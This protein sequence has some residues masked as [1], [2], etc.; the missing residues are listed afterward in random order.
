MR[1]PNASLAPT[2]LAAAMLMAGQHGIIP[3]RVAR[4]EDPQEGPEPEPPPSPPR[5][6]VSAFSHYLPY[7]ECYRSTSQ[8]SR[9]VSNTGTPEAAEAKRQRK[10]AKRAA[11]IAKSRLTKHNNASKET[12]NS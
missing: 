7:H 9:T 4:V 1:R 10:A 5:Y 6:G 3:R 2:L 8:E 11:D 12:S